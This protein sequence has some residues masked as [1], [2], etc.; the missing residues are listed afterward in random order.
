M[1]KVYNKLVRDRI[2]EIIRSDGYLP[3]TRKLGVKEFKK[4]L[5]EK[6][7]EEAKEVT[8]AKSRDDLLKELSDVEEI[9]FEMVVLHKISCPEIN[10]VRNKRKK[11]RGAFKKRLFLKSISK[12]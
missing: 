6:L 9:I 12:S 11:A 4:A 10:K 1:K 3:V 8:K 7:V 5:A 2:P